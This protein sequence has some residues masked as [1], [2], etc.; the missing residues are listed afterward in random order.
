MANSEKVDVVIAGGGAAGWLLAAK[1]GQAGKK[2]V[3]L[4]QG[5]AWKTDDLIS[6]QIWARRLKWGGPPVM[7]DGKDPDGYYLNTGWGFGGAATHHYAN[8]PRLHPEDFR[9]K[10]QFGRG[11]DWPIGYDDLRPYYDRVQKE[12][13]ISGDAAAE[14]WRPPGEPYP[15]PPMALTAQGRAVARGFAAMGLKTAPMPV[16]INSVAYQGRPACIYDGW[17]D[18]GCP[19][20]ALANPLVTY[21]PTALAAGAVAHARCNVTRVLTND[22]G[23]RATG[24]E[25][26]DAEGQ[27]QAQMADIVVLA[28][29]AVQNPRILLNSATDRHPKGLANS[30]DLV[31][32]YFMAHG[33]SRVL[34]L[35][36][37]DLQPYLG[38]IG[39]NLMSQEGYQKDAHGGPFGSYTWQITSAMKPNDFSGMAGTRPDLIGQD[40][41]DFMHR[42][43]RGLATLNALIEQLPDPENRVTLSAKK[44]RF[45]APLANLTHANGEDLTGLFQYTLARGQSIMHA[46]GAKEVWPMNGL[47]LIHVMGGTIM[48]SGVENSVCN[49]YGQ[50]HEIANLVMAGTGLHPTE[51]GVHPTFTVHALVMRSADHMLASWGSIVT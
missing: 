11:L 5:P 50:T 22:R 39:N 9:M 2:V 14:V 44:D 12:V 51:G 19:T 6:S 7:L 8:W 41:H 33:G 45:G 31:G 30:H 32:R 34:G 28:A 48:G 40:L 10:S 25:Y 27:R 24:V 37:E 17:C 21:M 18:A 20:G 42:A 43:A 35:F 36:D 49:S 29:N 46:A 26:Y 47:G 23:D 13:G 4:E 38:I 15:M 16:A 1:L 3:I